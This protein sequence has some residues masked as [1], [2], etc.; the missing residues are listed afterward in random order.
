MGT[1]ILALS[2]ATFPFNVDL[3]ESE[4]SDTA[5]DFCLFCRKA[6]GFCWIL[7][8]G[9]AHLWY[10]RCLYKLQVALLLDVY[11]HQPGFLYELVQTG[12][13]YG[14]SRSTG[15][16]LFALSYSPSKF[17]ISSLLE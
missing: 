6:L 1:M 5:I 4:S 9:I 13:S 2:L 12:H 17:P 10:W 11:Q 14:V 7:H 16:T 3:L 15:T 8:L